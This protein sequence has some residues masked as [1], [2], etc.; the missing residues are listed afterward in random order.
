[1]YEIGTIIN[2]DH[3]ATQHLDLKGASAYV[4]G[5]YAGSVVVEIIGG[6]EDGEIINFEPHVIEAAVAAE[7]KPFDEALELG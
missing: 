1:M 3:I 4:M 7:R 6:A 2:A 5:E